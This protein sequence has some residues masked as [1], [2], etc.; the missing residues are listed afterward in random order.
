MSSKNGKMRQLKCVETLIVILTD[1][2]DINII[3][4]SLER[5]KFTKRSDN[6]K[7]NS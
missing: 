7:S 5:T 1:L 4:Q 3:S 2:K 6:E